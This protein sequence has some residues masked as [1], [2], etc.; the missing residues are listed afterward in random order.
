MVI[1]SA[2][3]VVSEGDVVVKL[4]SAFSR[5]SSDI[6]VRPVEELSVSYLITSRSCEK[7]LGLRSM[8]IVPSAPFL[9]ELLLLFP[10]L[11]L[12]AIEDPSQLFAPMLIL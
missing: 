10:A 12:L 8:K 7:I 1:S 4:H 2:H 5:S 3:C 11:P 6:E 9:P